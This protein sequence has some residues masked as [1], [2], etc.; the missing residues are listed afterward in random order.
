M[1]MI[2][3]IMLSACG[4]ADAGKSFQE[5]SEISGEVE[6]KSDEADTIG[7]SATEVSDAIDE[8]EV[9]E[10]VETEETE[11]DEG[12][13]YHIERID[14]SVK[15]SHGEIVAECYY[16]K[17]V[18][19]KEEYQAC[20][21]VTER[22]ADSFFESTGYFF[23]YV[24]EGKES[25][26]TEGYFPYCNLQQFEH[27]EYVGDYVS[28]RLSYDWYAGGVTE[29]DIMSINMDKE[30]NEITVADVLDM[31]EEECREKAYQMTIDFLKEIDSYDPMM[32]SNLQNYQV[33]D[34]HFYL[35][36]H[37]CYLIYQKYEIADGATGSIEIEFATY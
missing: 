37:T 25:D 33:S 6:E 36:N 1:L 8:I 34:Y 9:S 26:Y 10:S 14:N 28:I 21:A 35:E 22:Y 16:D 11:T 23:E 20:N 29:A 15:N 17:V 12:E 3:G 7:T 31:P 30:G 32:T 13:W 18:F 24:E 19:D 2:V 5:S 4:G 27:V